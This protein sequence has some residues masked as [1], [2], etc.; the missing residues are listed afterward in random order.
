M[1]DTRLERR[2]GARVLLY[3]SAVW[4]KGMVRVT[5]FHAELMQGSDAEAVRELQKACL[6]EFDRWA[7]NAPAQAVGVNPS[8]AEAAARSALLDVREL[9][10]DYLGHSLMLVV[11]ALRL[12]GWPNDAG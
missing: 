3:L 4:R 12:S 8:D 6:A 7:K 2:T 10:D 5:K 9:L 11:S 1:R